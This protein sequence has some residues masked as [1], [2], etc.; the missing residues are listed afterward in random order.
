MRTVKIGDF[1]SAHLVDEP[2]GKEV[3]TVKYRSPEIFR[4]D[5]A[6][7]PAADCWYEL[8]DEHFF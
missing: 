3:T 8:F 1:G 2:R 6:P 4:G 5:A 7:T